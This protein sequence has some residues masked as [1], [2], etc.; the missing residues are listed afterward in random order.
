[1]NCHDLFDLIGEAKGEYIREARQGRASTA[2]RLSPKKLVL[3]AAILVLSLL[4]VGCTVA[5]VQGWFRDFFASKSGSPLSDS[6]LAFLEDN[7]QKISKPQT[8][9][10]WTVELR[11]VISDGTQGHILLGVTAPK[12]VS[13]DTVLKNG[14]TIS[15]VKVGNG[16][17]HSQTELLAMPDGI[18]SSYSFCFEED[19][20]GIPYTAN[21][22]LQLSPDLENCSVDPFG[23]D[24]V[25][26][27]AMEDIYRETVNEE[28]WDGI[29]Q[30]LTFENAWTDELLVQGLWE[31]SF[32]FGLAPEDVIQLEML[33]TPFTTTALS[34]YQYGTDEFTDAGW[35]TEE[36]TVTSLILKPL[37]VTLTYEPTRGQPGTS[38]FVWGKQW[39]CY[40]VMKDGRKIQLRHAYGS[41][42]T[43]YRLQASAPLVLD[44]VDHI[45][46]VDGTEIDLDGTV[47][48]HLWKSAAPI[49]PPE[50]LI[51]GDSSQEQIAAYYAALPSALG[52][53]AYCNDFDGDG[54][55]DAAIWNDGS[56]IALCTLTEDGVLKEWTIF[57]Q[58]LSLK[59][60]SSQYGGDIPDLLESAQ[61]LKPV[62][63]F[64]RY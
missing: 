5:Y 35:F 22:V 54:I 31:F 14:A 33:S 1:M 62:L 57:E 30:I 12:D 27:I 58:A 44:E 8:I 3:I 50:T 32:S 60:L 37:S 4:L 17:L 36:H 49:S 18:S 56:Y 47:K 26:H 24:A 11:S 25:Y 43:T 15:H 19:G 28:V 41:N 10:G 20:D 7:E 55:T 34:Y 42:A 51:P 45:Q 59:E 38:R 23:V 53:H 61:V 63:E 39:N 40:A 13:L 46:M 48:S 9:N 29:S 6:Q 2:H 16:M 64:Y 52:I 21:F